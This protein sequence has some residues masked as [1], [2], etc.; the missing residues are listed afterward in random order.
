MGRGVGGAKGEE[1]Q[2][3]GGCRE[4]GGGSLGP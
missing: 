3:S 1:K 2:V 4:E